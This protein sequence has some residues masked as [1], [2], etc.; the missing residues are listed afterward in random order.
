MRGDSLTT[1]TDQ[2]CRG[3]GNSLSTHTLNESYRRKIGHA[4]R[5]YNIGVLHII[6]IEVSGFFV[7]IK[8]L[9]ILRDEKTIFTRLN[10]RQ[11]LTKPTKQLE[12]EI[13]III[14][15]Y[16]IVPKLVDR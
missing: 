15:T 8:V 10:N 1:A 4:V 6:K 5:F 11:C 7:V 9:K 12:C 16:D 13:D 2:N 14:D 3:S